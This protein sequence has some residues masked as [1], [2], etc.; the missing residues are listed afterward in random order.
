MNR[1]ISV[2][3][4]GSP[5]PSLPAAAWDAGLRVLRGFLDGVRRVAVKAGEDDI[6]FLAQGIAFNAVIAAIPFLLLLVAIFGFVLQATVSDP[7]QAAADYVISI[8]PATP[9]VVDT[10][11]DLVEDLVAGRTRFGVLGLALFVWFSTSLIGSLR[12]AL[13][14][15]FDLQDD[16]GVLG[17]KLYDAVMVIVAGSLFVLNTG[18]TLALETIQRFGI[19]WLGLVG[20]R[21]ERIVGALYAQLA[22]FAF[23][24]LMFALIYRYLP[25][26]RTPWRIALVAATFTATVWELLKSLFTWYIGTYATYTT[27]Y[28][29]IATVIVV[30]FWIYYSAVVFVLGGEVGQVYDMYRT[31]RRQ[32]EMLE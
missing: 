2:S 18:I 25:A 6:F 26:R 16:R 24:F 9:A 5:R 10:A 31:R 17:G 22:A 20:G 4:K 14:D 8:L 11:R 28:G 21:E 27:T 13:R 15:I 23:I 1:R 19:G 3:G 12:I 7:G 32:R 29:N 30:I